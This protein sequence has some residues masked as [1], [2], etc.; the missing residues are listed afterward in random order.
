MISSIK[1]QIVN[2]INMSIE[3]VRNK[4]VNTTNKIK[5]VKSRYDTTSIENRITDIK[6]KISNMKN[7]EV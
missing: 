7:I 1:K 2:N 6:N 4:Y 3:Y 5:D